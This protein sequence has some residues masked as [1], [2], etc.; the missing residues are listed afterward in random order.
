M[1]LLSALRALSPSLRALW[2]SRHCERKRSNLAYSVVVGQIA[3]LVSS[4]AMTYDNGGRSVAFWP[5][6]GVV[7]AGVSEAIYWCRH[8]ER[9]VAIWPIPMWSARLLRSYPRSQ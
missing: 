2:G 9:S 6:N 7:I 8:C 4:F 1:L 3:S 5:S